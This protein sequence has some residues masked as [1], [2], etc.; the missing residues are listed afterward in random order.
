MFCALISLLIEK[1]RINLL[2]EG[3]NQELRVYSEESRLDIYLYDYKYEYN[4]VQLQTNC[5][6][7]KSQYKRNIL[8]FQIYCIRKPILFIYLIG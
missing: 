8:Y 4:S 5:S 7:V 1:V 2:K 6:D 3:G